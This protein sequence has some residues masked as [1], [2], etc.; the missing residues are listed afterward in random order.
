MDSHLSK[1]SPK[2]GT[3]L[4]PFC[5]P[6]SQHGGLACDPEINIFRTQE[7]MER[8][9]P[10][11]CSVPHP[12]SLCTFYPWG[13]TRLGPHF[14]QLS[15]QCHLLSD[16]FL[17]PCCPLPSVSTAAHFQ[18][19]H[20]AHHLLALLSPQRDHQLIPVPRTES[21]RWQALSKLLGVRVM[22]EASVSPSGKGK[23]PLCGLQGLSHVYPQQG[24]SVLQSGGPGRPEMVGTGTS[25]SGGP[26]G[27]TSKAPHRAGQQSHLTLSVQACITVLARSLVCSY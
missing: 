20:V 5:F 22:S 10:W 25:L 18:P 21:G 26:A 23:S 8:R 17:A 19:L 27:V 7:Y 14:L 13:P 3:H 11:G 6:C 12:P 1:E 24:L 4:A 2:L 16:V 9:P 15:A